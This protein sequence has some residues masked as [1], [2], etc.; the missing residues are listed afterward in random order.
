MTPAP[1]YISSLQNPQVRNLVKLRQRRAR[2][3]QAVLVIEETLVIRRARDCG[4]PFQTIYFCREQ[5]TDPVGLTLLQELQAEEAER[6][7]FVELASYVMEKV[8]YRERPEGLLVVAPQVRRELKALTLPDHPLLLVAE[9]L[10]K[11]GNLG[12]LLRIADGAGADAV[13]LADP[14][15]DLFNPNVLRASRGAVFAVPTIAADSAEV[16]EFLDR[17]GV[18][19]VATT[20]AAEQLYTDV[21][22]RGPLAVIVGAEDQG[23]SEAWLANAEKQIRIPMQGTGDSL[24]VATAAALILYEAVRQRNQPAS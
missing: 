3:E 6:L 2:D 4:Q 21:D 13:L 15:T 18:R 20:S 10:E 16:R 23:L 22:L 1:L 19:C 24:N 8:S 14:V 5:L 12:A 7:Q 11:P 17:H 9:R